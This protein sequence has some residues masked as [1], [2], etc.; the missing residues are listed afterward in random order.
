VKVSTIGLQNVEQ[1]NYEISHRTFLR[2]NYTDEPVLLVENTANDGEFI[3]QVLNIVKR[4]HPARHF[5]FAL[6][7][8]G[9]STIVDC[10]K[11]EL[12]SQRITVCIVDS[13]KFS[14]HNFPSAT[15]R[16]LDGAANQN[17]Y[18]GG[19][20]PTPCKEIENFIPL[21]LIERHRLC[22]TY[23]DFDTLKSLIQRQDTGGAAQN[24]C[25]LYFD[26]KV[27]LSGTAVLAKGL[28]ADIEAWVR[29]QFTVDNSR[30]EDT[31][32]AGFGPNILRSFLNSN[33]AINDYK[34]FTRTSIWNAVFAPFLENISWFLAADRR[35][36]A[37]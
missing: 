32:I 3:T 11:E 17:S 14:P 4:S 7:H 19:V 25:W 21:D 2:G 18:V 20:F 33:P 35:K 15:L 34:N 13:D 24:A 6:R 10:F 16:A 5:A 1:N 8:G 28:H 29:Q 12:R 9:G 37:I 30:L 27:G 23:P 36:S 22:P 26:L 31:V